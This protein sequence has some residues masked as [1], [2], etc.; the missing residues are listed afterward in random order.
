M[1]GIYKITNK[2]NNKAYI[3]QSLNIETRW[4]QH[5]AN[6]NS[7]KDNTIYQAL[8]K[9]GLNNFNFEVVEEC[10]EN[11]LDEREIYWI[12]YYNSYENGYNMNRGGATGR[13]FDYQYLVE[14]YKKY[15]TIEETAKQCNCHFHTISK[16]LKA[17]NITPNANSLGIKRAIKQ[18]DPQTYKVVNIYD[19]IADAAKAMGATSNAAISKALAGHMNVAYG[20]IWKDIDFDEQ[21]LIS[22]N[23][24]IKNMHTKQILQQLNK[25][26]EEVIAEYNNV[27]E[28]LLALNRNLRDGAI[29]QV[30]KG[31]A[32][33]A[34][35]F[36][37]RFVER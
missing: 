15:G 20:F 18:I 16:A 6:I 26:T 17:Y 29:Y 36:K 12:A 32:K 9:Y 23:T 8:R 35:G 25:E 28:A 34:Y 10:S 5:I 27:K 2:I 1:I 37:W 4:K 33:T 30:C 24:T 14:Q 11:Q 7:D 31:K 22:A 3:G 21:Q 19:S 13:L